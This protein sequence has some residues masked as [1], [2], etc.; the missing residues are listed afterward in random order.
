MPATTPARG[1]VG[2]QRILYATDYSSASLPALRHALALTKLS[3]AQLLVLHVVSPNLPF[4]VDAEARRR[5][6]AR[7][8]QDAKAH[9]DEV[10]AVAAKAGIR[11]K[12]ILRVGE[13]REEI[14]GVASAQRADLVVIG[15]HGRTGIER[16]LMGSVATS[17]INTCPIPVLS[18]RDAGAPGRK[19]AR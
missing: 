8:K 18:V 10:L 1:A 17:V 16:A 4:V 5:I 12:G 9:L 2:P 13:P 19:R 14:V 15:T 6:L 11:A 3:G 7:M